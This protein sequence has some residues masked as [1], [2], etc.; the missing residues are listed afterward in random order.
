MESDDDLIRRHKIKDK[1]CSA[2]KQMLSPVN[3]NHNHRHSP[4]TAPI[5]LQRAIYW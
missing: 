1:V 3:L 5:P 4:S 2:N